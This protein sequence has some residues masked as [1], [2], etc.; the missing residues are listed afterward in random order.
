[1]ATFSAAGRET[2]EG[3][4][5]AAIA[6]RPNNPRCV[7]LNASGAPAVNARLCWRKLRRVKFFV[8]IIPG[9]LQLL[10]WSLAP[11]SQDLSM[12]QVRLCVW[13][14]ALGLLSSVPRVGASGR[15]DQFLQ[16]RADSLV[17]R[18]VGQYCRVRFDAPVFAGLA[19]KVRPP[20]AVLGQPLLT[21]AFP[22][23]QHARPAFVPVADG[24]LG[25]FELSQIPV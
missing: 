4:S 16:I 17:G 5:G 6:S 24:F 2:G 9:Q 13:A 11:I 3:L 19:V 25:I 1:M 10:N 20:I 18:R 15:A 21:P 22:I 12:S 7:R 23:H 14:K 8:F